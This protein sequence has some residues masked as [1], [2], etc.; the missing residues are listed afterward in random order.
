MKMNVNAIIRHG[1]L[2]NGKSILP[3]YVESRSTAK[4][5]VSEWTSMTGIEL[6][7]LNL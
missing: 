4:M 5:Q 1:I 2:F 6:M 7:M 3:P